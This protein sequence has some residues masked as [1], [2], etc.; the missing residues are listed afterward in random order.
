MWKNEDVAEKTARNKF[1]WLS[2][3][4]SD[5]PMTTYGRSTPYGHKGYL[6]EML[7]IVYYVL[8]IIPEGIKLIPEGLYP[9]YPLHFPWN[10]PGVKNPESPTYIVRVKSSFQLDR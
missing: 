7:V 5:S 4:L 1:D 6:Q 2:D 10:I 3:W 9:D 8:S